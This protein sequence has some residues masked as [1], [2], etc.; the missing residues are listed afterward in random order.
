MLAEAAPSS[1]GASGSDSAGFEE[2]REDEVESE[3]EDALL[4]NT[5]W[6][7]CL[8]FVKYTLAR[9]RARLV[10]LSESADR[11]VSRSKPSA[12]ARGRGLEFFR[13]AASGEADLAGLVLDFLPSGPPL[14]GESLLS[15]FFLLL[16]DGDL[17]GDIHDRRAKPA[18]DSTVLDLSSGFGSS[19]DSTL[20]LLS[21]PSEPLSFADGAGPSGFS[22]LRKSG[23][24]LELGSH[25]RGLSIMDLLRRRVST[26]GSTGASAIFLTPTSSSSLGA[27]GAGWR[28]GMFNFSSRLKVAWKSWWSKS[29]EGTSKEGR[30]GGKGRD[31]RL[32]VRWE[33]WSLEREEGEEEEAAAVFGGV[34]LSVSR[35]SRSGVECERWNGTFASTAGAIDRVRPVISWRGFG[36][37]TAAGSVA[38]TLSALSKQAP[39]RGVQRV[40]WYGSLP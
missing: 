18:N 9:L 30:E 16:G 4:T 12:S 21:L 38:S 40:L 7:F 32:E 5:F 35:E 39:A 23:E 25:R 1:N 14:S 8:I 26:S 27:G 29:K 22:S 2:T 24:D 37:A 15:V 6:G 33:G 20:E 11:L 36:R 3:E 17:E 34:A 10:L 19:L 31:L 13:A 28:F